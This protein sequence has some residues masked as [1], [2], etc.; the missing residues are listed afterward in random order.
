VTV[1]V[2]V[3]VKPQPRDEFVRLGNRLLRFDENILLYER[4]DLAQTG[5]RAGGDAKGRGR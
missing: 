3:V 5:Y 2:V 1:V 4:K